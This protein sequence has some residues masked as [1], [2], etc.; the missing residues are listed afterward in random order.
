MSTPRHPYPGLRA[1][2]RNESRLFF[3][4]REQIADLL[5]RLKN[6][7]FL[8][9]LG[10]SGSGKSSLMKAGVLPALEKGYMGE[11]V[12]ARWSIAEMRPAA[13]P[14]TRLAEGLLQDKLFRAAWQSNHLEAE[15]V[16]L[17]AAELR[18]GSRSLSDLLQ[19][20]ALPQGTRLLL[21]VDQFEELFRFSEQ[22]ESAEL[23]SNTAAAFIALLL[24]ASQHDDIYVAITMRSDFLGAAVQ[25]HGLPEAINDGLYL[26]PRLTRAQLR[27]AI[28]LPALMFDGEIEDALA[29]HLLNEASSQALDQVQ[30]GV[31]RQEAGNDQ[32][33]L[34]QHAL[35]RL[36][37]NGNGTTL[38]QYQQ[39]GGL[40]GAL[41]G[42]AEELWNTLSASEQTIAEILFRALTERNPDGK[43][44]RRPVKAQTVRAM[45]NPEQGD[46]L[47]NVIQA[48]RQS[49]CNFLMPPPSVELTPDTMLDISHESLMRQWQ[50]LQTWVAAEADKA[51]L[52]AQL[53]AAVRSDAE[54]WRG[55]DL[56]KA[57]DWAQ[58]TRPTA[59]WAIRYSE[60]GDFERVQQFLRQSTA[61]AQQLA[62]EKEAHR[63][64]ELKRA[65]TQRLWF[66]A[67]FVIT[68]GLAIWA[69]QERGHAQTEAEKSQ[70]A[71]ILAKQQATRALKA[72]ATATSEAHHAELA[73]TQAQQEAARAV[74]AETAAKLSAQQANV[75]KQRAVTAEKQTKTMQVDLV[76]FTLASLLAKQQNIS[77]YVQELVKKGQQALLLDLTKAELG[78]GSVSRPC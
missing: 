25:F 16:G 78:K 46:A 13:Q 74:Q 5:T 22:N 71:E 26:T 70:R 7:H 28:C 65:K 42:H 75:A 33:P 51:A 35:M 64:A 76:K 1:F 56:A 77:D 6:N 32:L 66:F 45:L 47:N 68:S 67:G 10:A 19:P 23:S 17:L 31:S 50:R 9:V 49:G 69:W 4:R 11:T 2:E 34:L 15:P 29:N 55:K 58:T 3:G 48:F 53:L 44:T 41:D 21:L 40:R 62:A 59:A 39:L 54:D 20:L 73:R 60:A 61:K 24:E 36:W 38:A 57:E 52:Y 72:E 63:K 12:G 37:N 30:A 8:A 14:F 43:N 27:E 18:R